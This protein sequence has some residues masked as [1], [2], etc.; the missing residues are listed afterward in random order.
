[1]TLKLKAIGVQFFFFCYTT[2]AFSNDFNKKKIKIF[3][4]IGEETFGRISHKD[5]FNFFGRKI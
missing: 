2:N 3:Q 5:H 1:M 4:G